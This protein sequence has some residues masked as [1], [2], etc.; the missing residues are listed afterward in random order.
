MHSDYKQNHFLCFIDTC[1]TISVLIGDI[2][3]IRVITLNFIMGQEI[4][5]AQISSPEQ[6]NRPEV[7]E[8]M[9]WV[10]ASDAESVRQR[11]I[12]ER[13]AAT[14]EIIEPNTPSMPAIDSQGVEE[15]YRTKIPDAIAMNQ[16]PGSSMCVLG[17]LKFGF[18]KEKPHFVYL[19]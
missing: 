13:S 2:H 12:S 15:L 4:A 10:Y 5:T 16:I 18:P 3:T 8:I 17:I 1:A 19:K 7:E 14:V 11:V 6:P 9:Q